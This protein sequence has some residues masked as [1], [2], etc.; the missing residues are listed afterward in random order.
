MRLKGKNALV[1]AAGQG[2]GRASAMA[3]AAE[4]AHVW[5]TDVNAKLLESYK[6]VASHSKAG[7]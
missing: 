4:G 6:G 1:T 2:I 3:L 5:A 7:G